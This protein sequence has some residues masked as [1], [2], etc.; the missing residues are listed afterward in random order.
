MVF[1]LA[2]WKEARFEVMFG[3]EGKGIYGKW[4]EWKALFGSLK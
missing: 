4:T 1:A 2:D 3:E